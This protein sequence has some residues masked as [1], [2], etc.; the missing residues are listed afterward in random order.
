M[1]NKKL[2]KNIIKRLNNTIVSKQVIKFNYFNK[3]DKMNC[4]ADVFKFGGRTGCYCAAQL[5]IVLHI[6]VLNIIL[7]NKAR[8]N[9]IRYYY[10]YVCIMAY[11]K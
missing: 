7:L 2:Q 1:W 4:S 11:L 9:R 10:R 3:F 6:S 8:T 5:C